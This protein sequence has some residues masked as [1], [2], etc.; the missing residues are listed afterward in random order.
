MDAIAAFDQIG[1]FKKAVAERNCKMVASMTRFPLTVNADGSSDQVNDETALCKHFDVLFNE[2]V[3]RIVEEQDTR[4][5]GV[6]YRG[7]KFGTGKLWLQPSCSVD[8]ADEEC[9][10]DTYVL[11]LVTI[12]Q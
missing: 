5:M 1:V 3:R 8:A 2:E 11:K 12:N 9:S 4:E 6:G 10:S 7:F